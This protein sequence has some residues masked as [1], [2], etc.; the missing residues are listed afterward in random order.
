MVRGMAA[1]DLQIILE[2]PFRGYLGNEVIE[3]QIFYS[4]FTELQK[5]VG[6]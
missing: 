2:V 3:S 4:H 1:L 5:I 6:K